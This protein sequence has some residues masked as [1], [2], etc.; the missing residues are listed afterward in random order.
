MKLNSNRTIIVLLLLGFGLTNSFADLVVANSPANIQ[1]S[2]TT[3]TVNDVFSR[4]GFYTFKQ[5]LRKCPSPICGGIFVKKVNKDKT[6]CADGSYQT[7]CYV[8][9]INWATKKTVGFNIGN[10]KILL[11]GSIAKKNFPGFGI[12]GIFKVNEAYRPLTNKL[13]DSKTLYAGLENNGLLCITTPCFSFDE[14]ILNTKKTRLI[15]DIDLSKVNLPHQ[16]FTFPDLSTGKVLLA[17]G[18]NHQTN[19]PFGV[20]ITFVA[21]EIYVPIKKPAGICPIGYNAIG[22]KCITPIGCV[23]PE[24]ELVASGGVAYIDPITGE[25]KSNITKS[26]VVSCEPPGI[27]DKPAHCSVFYP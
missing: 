8:T 23:A 27:L 2:I 16:V 9:A 15:S 21:N 11:Q 26:C 10:K 7:E 14:H 22:G 25:V 18:H 4:D 12:L 13:L 24:I 20:G 19:L 1:N 6:L 17:A 5:D 3:P